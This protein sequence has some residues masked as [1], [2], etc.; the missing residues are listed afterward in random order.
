MG[1]TALTAG[2]ESVGGALEVSCLGRGRRSWEGA[3]QV[4][5]DVRGV[6]GSHPANQ[7][8]LRVG[9]ATGLCRLSTLP[10]WGKALGE[11]SASPPPRPKAPGT[12]APEHSAGWQ[13]APGASSSRLSC[14]LPLLDRGVVCLLSSN[15]RH[16]S[17][18]HSRGTGGP[19]PPSEGAGGGTWRFLWGRRSSLGA[20]PAMQ[21]GFSQHSS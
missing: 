5:K 9:E 11:A 21:R 17:F 15:L 4:R 2:R 12:R 16:T 14:Q 7:A 19:P 6:L 1:A 13:R 10:G 18:R 8:Q 20:C 3:E